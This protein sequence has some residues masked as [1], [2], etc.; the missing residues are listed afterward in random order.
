MHFIYTEGTLPKK[1]EKEPSD[2]V[3]IIQLNADKNKT[4]M[5]KMEIQELPTLLIYKNKNS[6]WRH[7]SFISEEDLRKKFQ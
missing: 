6:S 7:S 2:K 4:L 1:I 3:I 5:S